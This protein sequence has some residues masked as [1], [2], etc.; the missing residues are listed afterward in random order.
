MKRLILALAILATSSHASSVEEQVIQNKQDTIK[1]IEQIR[2]PELL[3]DNYPVYQ[4]QFTVTDENNPRKKWKTSIST[5]G[6]KFHED[7]N[8]YIYYDENQTGSTVV[9]VDKK[10]NSASI[11]YQNESG[12]IM[13]TGDSPKCKKIN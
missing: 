4:C 10:N 2:H 13:S 3:T 5:A 1:Q 7:I 8:T 6:V 12:D 11:V 9:Y